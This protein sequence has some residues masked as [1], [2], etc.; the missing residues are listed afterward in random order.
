MEQFVDLKKEKKKKNKRKDSL[1][2]VSKSVRKSRMR[3]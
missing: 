1:C 3:K 2:L